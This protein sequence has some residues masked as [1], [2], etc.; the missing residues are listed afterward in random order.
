MSWA[1]VLASGLAGSV[2]TLLTQAAHRWWNKPVLKI[3][4]NEKGCRVE[5]PAWL[6]DEDKNV[7]VDASGQPRKI[8]QVYLRLRIRNPGRTFARNA[9][10]CV[11][12]ITYEPKGLD[13]VFGEEVLDPKMSLTG[14][15]PL[16]NLPSGAYCFVDLVHTEQKVGRPV[17]LKFDFVSWP[18]RMMALGFGAGRY[19]TGGSKARR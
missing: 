4:P 8:E 3:E 2:L 13:G 18:V 17:E 7:V 16:F 14:D 10:V 15:K 9:S 6:V 12:E 11:T 19:N 5:T 1:A